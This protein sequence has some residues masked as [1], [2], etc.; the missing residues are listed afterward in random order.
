MDRIKTWL[1]GLSFAIAAGVAALLIMLGSTYPIY[2]A[3]FWPALVIVACGGGWLLLVKGKVARLGLSLI[4]LLLGIWVLINVA[5]GC[6]IAKPPAVTVIPYVMP[7]IGLGQIGPG[8]LDLMN[9]LAAGD[10][11][12]VAPIVPAIVSFFSGAG[13]VVA[14]AASSLGILGAMRTKK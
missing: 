2:H 4:V 7:L 12:F 10:I 14:I 13:A 9:D 6:S 3:H 1:I 5:S 11:T 8:T